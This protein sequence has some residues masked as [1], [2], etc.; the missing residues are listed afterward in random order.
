MRIPRVSSRRSSLAFLIAVP[1][2]LAA[3]SARGAPP[4]LY[5]ATPSQNVTCPRSMPYATTTNSRI[6]HP[7]VVLVFWQD[8]YLEQWT[9]PSPR[10]PTMTQTIGKTLSLLDGA[11]AG[12]LAQYGT[13]GGATGYIGRP[14]LSPVVD[15]LTGPQATGKTVSTPSRFGTTSLEYILEREIAAGRVPA[16]QPASSPD[17]VVYVFVVPGNDAASD[18]GSGGCNLTW[19][20]HGAYY[21][22]AL[23]QQ[24]NL[25]LELSHEIAEAIVDGWQGFGICGGPDANGNL[26]PGCASNGCQVNGSGSLGRGT[27]GIADLCCAT[28]TQNGSQ[29]LSYWSVQDGRCVVPESWG[30]L[31]SNDG[32]GRGWV[33]SQGSFFMRQIAGG[34]GGVAATDVKDDI[35]FY[36]TLTG[37]WRGS[38][39][40]GQASQL[41]A[42]GHNVAAVNLDAASVRYYDL[43]YQG[44][45]QLGA[46]TSSTGVEGVTGVTVTAAG[47]IAVTD[48]TG[49]P[50]FWNWNAQ[51]PTWTQMDSGPVDQLVAAGNDLL[52]LSLDRAFVYDFPGTSMGYFGAPT[53][54]RYVGGAAGLVASSDAYGTST[55]GVQMPGSTVFLSHT[56]GDPDVGTWT[57]GFGEYA[58]NSSAY[59]A[60]FTALTLGGL[61]T[62]GCEVTGCTT[63]GWGP[64]S[65]MG[66]RLVSGGAQLVAACNSGSTPCVS[67]VVGCQP[68]TPGC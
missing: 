11:W 60:N 21:E 62:Y 39:L 38:P 14:R 30:D 40:G 44:W 24:G 15:V 8:R 23:V 37:A 3:P 50:W 65:G 51:P 10:S 7:E 53:L 67:T 52:T 6:Q 5:C 29:V 63:G 68:G 42:G 25:D 34:A 4:P 33:E 17:D 47:W 20:Y 64:T 49:V 45:G 66:G 13:Y 12:M 55:Y 59:G 46:P 58:A 41:A 19:N 54:L 35:H 43:D 16:P 56:A 28:E 26:A 18:C 61:Q 32:D 1:C 22:I 27:W 36:D 57:Q 2:L 9:G 48:V 31:Y